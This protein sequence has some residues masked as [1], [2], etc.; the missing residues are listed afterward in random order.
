MLDATKLKANDT[1]YFTYDISCVIITTKVKHIEY[2]S[3]SYWC[4]TTAHGSYVFPWTSAWTYFNTE[5]EAKDS[6]IQEINDKINELNK[7]LH[8]WQNYI[9]V[10]NAE[11]KKSP[12]SLLEKKHSCVKSAVKTKKK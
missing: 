1:I 11:L 12:L 9:P 6:K 4:V 5:Q 3:E 2:E 7:E 8:K 10:K